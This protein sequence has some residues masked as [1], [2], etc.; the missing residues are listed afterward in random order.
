MFD[1]FFHIIYI[2][3][4]NDIIFVYILSYHIAFAVQCFR[5]CHR[6]HRF[7]ARFTEVVHVCKKLCTFHRCC[8][9]FT[10][11]PAPLITFVFNCCGR[12]GSSWGLL[13]RLSGYT[14]Y[15][16]HNIYISQYIY[17]L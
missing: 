14:I 6:I 16:Y 13:T 3:V 12:N 1:M 8:A 10:S 4:F 9:R 11:P 17:I 2:Y 5:T 15:I 7:C